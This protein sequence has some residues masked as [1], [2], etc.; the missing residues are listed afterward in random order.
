M[1]V[2]GEFGVARVRV[3]GRERLRIGRAPHCEVT[4]DGVALSREH[5]ELRVVEGA[6][7]LRDLGSRAGT[8][9]DGQAIELDEDWT[10][11]PSDDPI[12][13]AL[14]I[15]TS[16]ALHHPR[17]QARPVA[18]LRAAAITELPDRPS[19]AWTLFLPLGGPLWTAPDQRWPLTL[20]F[21]EGRP[22]LSCAADTWV[23][24]RGE[25]LGPGAAVELL[26]DDRL[27]IE[28]RVGEPFEIE[29]V[30]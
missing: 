16:F 2:R 13:L 22:V 6:L 3:I 4:I 14:G 27:R 30:A 20:E 9:V 25:P 1:I 17:D 28:P 23:Q 10:L 15:A 29:I 8:F 26:I 12:E 21:V 5:A 11:D 18:L 24:L 19:F 7:V